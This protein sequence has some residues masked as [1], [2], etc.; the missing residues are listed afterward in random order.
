MT[1]LAVTDEDNQLM[2]I[3]EDVQKG[4]LRSELKKTKYK[5]VFWGVDLDQGGSLGIQL[6]MP[7]SLRA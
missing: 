7:R 1:V 5:S 3:A 4:R 6:V 2:N